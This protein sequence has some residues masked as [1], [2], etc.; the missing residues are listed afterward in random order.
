MRHAARIAA[1]ALGC[2]SIFALSACGSEEV[3]LKQDDPNY[4]GAEIF[5]Q[6]CAGCHTLDVAGAHGS[7]TKAS[8]KEISDGPN[9]NQ[10][11]ETVANVLYALENGGFSG[12]IMPPNLVTG[13]EAQ[14]VAEFLAKYAGR[15]AKLPPGPTPTS[16]DEEAKHGDSGSYSDSAARTTAGAATTPNPTA[17][18]PDSGE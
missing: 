11:T 9:F 16:P 4:K 7:S 10:R 8:D 12:K 2:S 18:E 14:A 13:E 1:F 6:R 15:E 17:T 5:A 3:A